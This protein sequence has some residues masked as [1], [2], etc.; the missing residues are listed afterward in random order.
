MSEFSKVVVIDGNGHLAG[1]LASI[2]A[3][4]LLSG[5]K[6]VVVRCEDIDISGSFFRNKLKYHAYLNKR[7]IVNPRHGA[8]HFR[9]PSRMFYR[10]VRG[11]T[12]HKLP[13]GAKALENLKVFEGVPP[14][15]NKMKRVVVPNALRVLRLKPNRKFTQLG[16][17]ATS[18]GWKYADVVEKLEVQRKTRAADFYKTKKANS[19]A[20]VQ[21]KTKAATKLKPVEKTLTQYGYTL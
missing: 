9:A 21:A 8:F 10:I 3:K 5:Q 6:V 4:Q 11:M 12:P 18:V 17:I 1:R 2:V 15:Y 13:R 20:L 16:K 19:R 7:C 14:P